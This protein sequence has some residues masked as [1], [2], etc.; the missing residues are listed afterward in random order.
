[1]KKK[2]SGTI[3]TP[4]ESR[5]M[6]G[7]FIIGLLQNTAILL[8]FSMLYDNLWI[9]RKAFQNPLFKIMVGVI[10]GSIGI[11][12]MLSPWELLPGTVFDTR[13]VMI[14][15]SGLF[16]G[17][18]PTLTAMAIDIAFR[19][20]MGGDGV[21]MG[22]TVI[23]TAGL[24]GILWKKFRPDWSQRNSLLELLAM[25]TLVHMFMLACTLLLPGDLSISTLKALAIPIVI[26][27]IPANVLLGKLM[28][29]QL[30][31]WQNKRIKEHL[32]E[33][34]RRFSEI[35]K[36]SNLLTLIVN[37]QGNI[38]FCNQQLL[39]IS[40]YQ[41]AEIENQNWFNLFLP[42]QGKETIIEKFHGIIQGNEVIHF[43]EHDIYK[44]N[45]EKLTINWNLVKL[46]DIDNEV[47]GIAC[48]GVNV[49]QRKQY[50]LNLVK[51]NRIIRDH[52]RKYRKMNQELI[53]AK[54]KAEESERL[55]SAFLA[56]MSHEIRTPM[57][58]ILGF[59]ELLQN[60][61][62]TSEEIKE[63]LEIINKSGARML[64]IIND[65]IEI[66]KVESGLIKTQVSAVN[67]N[68]QVK[69]LYN[70]F[71]PEAEAKG[72]RIEFATE[73]SDNNCLIASD[74]EKIYAILTNL[75]K[76]AIKYSNK[77]LIEFGYTIENEFLKF[78]IKDQGIGIPTYKQHA[79]FERFVQADYST[80]SFYEGA[81]LGLS[82][83]KAYVE[84]LGGQIYVISEEGVGSQFYFT[85]PY[86]P[87]PEITSNVNQTA[88]KEFPN[89]ETNFL[90]ILVVD[91]DEISLRLISTLVG[92]YTN[93]V[94][95]AESGIKAI[96]LL[97]NGEVFDMIFI[98]V[99]MPGL[100]GLD[101]TRQIR[102][103]NREIIIIAQ[104]AYA[105]VGDKELALE[106]GCN[107]Y[108]TKPLKQEVLAEIFRKYAK[109]TT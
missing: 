58:G 41:T 105:L 74:K 93:S 2:A 72:L 97:R 34:E 29:K 94:T 98:D 22:I 90:K 25:G 89:Q 66:S 48:L 67:V 4:Y 59:A 39:E 109:E 47:T 91:D 20:T 86:K 16:F 83:A 56:N 42:E 26:V 107:D 95:K 46:T 51:K 14:S 7:S 60:P 63:Y 10:I 100:S 77:G 54:E 65:L 36:S 92:K 57:N 78:F 69:F 12:L 27:Y 50:E 19:W 70:F 37:T 6:S 104:T 71:K 43:F 96:E 8:S 13:S 61:D 1:M 28:L 84:M 82:I 45:K 23:L 32:L 73:L 75:L 101:A 102:Q 85:V 3:Y 38:T 15:I 79:I 49:T 17:A 81:G 52:I 24:T 80:S 106:A 64:N 108:I 44:K 87:I 103:F 31:N 30:Q 62:L 11:V 21:W 76:N 5:A 40:G 68:E 33:S 53:E 9:T 35:L 99:R 88:V 18:L 55:K